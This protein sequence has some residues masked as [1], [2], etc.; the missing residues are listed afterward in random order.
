MHESWAQ[1]IE[2]SFAF[3]FFR[4]DVLLLSPSPADTASSA[5]EPSKLVGH[6]AFRDPRLIYTT[7][8]SHESHF[9]R[10]KS[11]LARGIA[12]AVKIKGGWIPSPGLHADLGPRA[13]GRRR[14]AGDLKSRDSS[15]SLVPVSK[16]MLIVT[17]AL[18]QAGALPDPCLR[19]PRQQRCRGTSRPTVKGRSQ[20]K[21]M[22]KGT[23][24]ARR[25]WHGRPKGR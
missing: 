2:S 4:G 17:G 25:A 5:L 8:A 1:T 12:T 21:E 22:Q 6:A 18:G 10:Q 11:A 15:R 20:P 19:T 23:S 24:G 13:N 3:F 16:K 14:G 9:C 7:Q